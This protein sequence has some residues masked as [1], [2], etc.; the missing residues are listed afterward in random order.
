MCLTNTCTYSGEAPLVPVIQPFRLVQ[1]A[2]G[3]KVSHGRH[4]FAVVVS[5]GRP[6]GVHAAKAG[7][8][9]ASGDLKHHGPR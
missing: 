6:E 3:R 5:A 4:I 2:A 9:D 1:L 8:T 7:G